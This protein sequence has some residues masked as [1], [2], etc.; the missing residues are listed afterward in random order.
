ML[1][2]YDTT[3]LP[4]CDTASVVRNVSKDTWPGGF[5]LHRRE[6]IPVFVA[7]RNVILLH[8][9]LAVSAVREFT[10]ERFPVRMPVQEE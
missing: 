4:L 10:F 9:P 8:F 2:K 3:P 5:G 6:G 1:S 7:L